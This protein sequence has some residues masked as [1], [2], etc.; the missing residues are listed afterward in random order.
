MSEGEEL[1]RREGNGLGSRL[2]SSEGD[3][4][5]KDEGVELGEDDG[6]ALGSLEGDEVGVGVAGGGVLANGGQQQLS[7]FLLH[8]SYSLRSSIRFSQLKMASFV[9]QILSHLFLVLQN[10]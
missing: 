4:L 5:G 6:E 9:E 10:C 8:L 3:G 2:G 1:G 7:S